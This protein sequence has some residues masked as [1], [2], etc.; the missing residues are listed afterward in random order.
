MMKKEKI[1]LIIA[2]LDNKSTG[3]L[4]QLRVNSEQPVPKR[5]LAEGLTH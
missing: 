1:V 2:T 5:E 3:A 4:K